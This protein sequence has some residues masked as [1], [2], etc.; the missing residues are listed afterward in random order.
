MPAATRAVRQAEIRRLAVALRQVRRDLKVNHDQLWTIVDDI[1][2]G[3]ADRYG[4]GPVGA[5]Q[6]VVS[7]SHPGRCRTEPA[8]A[9]LAPRCQGPSP[10]LARTERHARQSSAAG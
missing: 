3:L 6:A 1:A 10:L 8:F 2:P 9:T 7:F 4:V 5:A